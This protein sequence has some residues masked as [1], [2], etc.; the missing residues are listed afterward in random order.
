MSDCTFSNQNPR[1][2][3]I[4]ETAKKRT[5]AQFSDI[6]FLT[7]LKKSSR[8]QNE[9]YFC[10]F[11]RSRSLITTEASIVI[12]RICWPFCIEIVKFES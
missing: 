2:A 11:G 12:H 3:F 8:A 9:T 10:E 5:D 4:R 1:I 6:I 7:E